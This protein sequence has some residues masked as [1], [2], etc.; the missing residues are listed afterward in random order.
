MRNLFIIMFLTISY[1]VL[2][3]EFQ[4]GDAD[5]VITKTGQWESTRYQVI[6]TLKDRSTELWLNSVDYVKSQC[7]LDRKK[8]EIKL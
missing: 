2:S 6:A 8:R 3:K 4:C 7:I 5:I 1:P